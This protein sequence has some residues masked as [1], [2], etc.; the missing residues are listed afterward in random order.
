MDLRARGGEAQARRRA[1]LRPFRH[2]VLPARLRL[3]RGHAVPVDGERLLADGRHRVRHRQAAARAGADNVPG[4]DMPMY[5][6]LWEHIRKRDAEEGRGKAGKTSTRS[7]CPSSCRRRSKRSTATTTRRSSS[8][9]RPAS[10]CRPVF[11]VVCNNTVDLE[12][13]LRLHLRLRA[14][15]R[16][17]RCATLEQRPPRAVPQLRRARQPAAP[18]RTRS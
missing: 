1:R 5:R 16:R 11:I 3:R 14:R 10:A 8:G 4:G 18:A 2:A 12:A 9:P 17:R 13:R 15:E 7:S 6:N